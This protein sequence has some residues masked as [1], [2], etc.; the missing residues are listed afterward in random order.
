MAQLGVHREPRPMQSWGWVSE[1]W[2]KAWESL[3]SNQVDT[4]E[5]RAELWG[6]RPPS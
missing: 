3:W 1:V 6:L 2:E 4:A 5:E